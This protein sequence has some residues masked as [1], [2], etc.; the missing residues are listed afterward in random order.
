MFKVAR[1][2][3]G[4]KVDSPVPNPDTRVFEEILFRIIPFSTG[5]DIEPQVLLQKRTAPSRA[6]QKRSEIGSKSWLKVQP[7]DQPLEPEPID[8]RRM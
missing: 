8:W 2:L 6:R 3:I 1:D 4:F 7:L 5:I